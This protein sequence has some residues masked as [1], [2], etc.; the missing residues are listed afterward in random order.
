MVLL[1]LMHAILEQMYSPSVAFFL[2]NFLYLYP[3]S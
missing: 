3:E 1:M 2:D